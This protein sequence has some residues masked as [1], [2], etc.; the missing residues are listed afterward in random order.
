MSRRRFE[1]GNFF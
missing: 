1:V